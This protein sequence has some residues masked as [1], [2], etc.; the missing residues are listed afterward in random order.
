MITPHITFYRRR[1]KKVIWGVII[2]TVP[3]CVCNVVHSPISILGN[4]IFVVRR[5]INYLRIYLSNSHGSSFSRFY[6]F[7]LSTSS[8][9]FIT[10]PCILLPSPIVIYENLIMSINAL[11]NF[12][13]WILIIRQ[14][15]YN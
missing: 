13:L 5:S 8:V 14:W 12:I 7:G 6:R 3:L 2:P 4:P 10:Y 15:C 11:Q 1:R 9:R